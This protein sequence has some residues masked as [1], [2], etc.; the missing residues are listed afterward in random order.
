[1]R[2]AIILAAAALGA[3]CAVSYLA[4]GDTLEMKNGTI[5]EG[6]YVGG[7]TGTVRVETAEGVKVVQTTDLLAITFAAAPTTA[8][9]AGAAAGAAAAVPAAA[10]VAPAAAAA[11]A[12]PKPVQV[13]AGTVLTIRM[14]S[15]VS[16]KDDK[17]KKFTGKLLA[18]L[19]AGDATVA[20]AGT[21]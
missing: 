6:K 19:M 3:T 14:D 20:K 16:S 11:P 12:A 7:S 1:M 2:H 15:Q 18:D 5:V 9:A 13:P 4:R 21:T 10:A 8:P 17:G